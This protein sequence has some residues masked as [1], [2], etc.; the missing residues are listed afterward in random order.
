MLSS[1]FADRLLL[2]R[3]SKNAPKPTKIATALA[4]VKLGIANVEQVVPNGQNDKNH[5]GNNDAQQRT[6]MHHNNNRSQPLF[7][8]KGVLRY[9][10]M[11][12]VPHLSMLVY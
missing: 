10:T 3:R 8:T 6:T 1:C 5:D 9:R 7:V 4:N 2:V 11:R 12:I